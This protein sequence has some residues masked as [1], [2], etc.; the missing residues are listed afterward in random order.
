MS[1]YFKI[2]FI[3]FLI[4]GTITV[5]DFFSK[6]DISKGS[7]TSQKDDNK[8]ESEKY[9]HVYFSDNIVVKAEIANSPDKKELGLSFR[10]NL[11]TDRGML[12]I[13]EVPTVAFFW[14]KD[15]RIPLD[16]IWIMDDKIVDIDK[17]VPIPKT[18]TPL[19]QLP[20]YSPSEKVNYVLEVNAGFTDKNSIE[21]GDVVTINF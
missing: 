13:F 4:L 7:D 21:V 9:A 3:L 1:K 20:K 18:D 12:F 15:M 16:I 6:S 5:Q 14:M 2:L 17:N 8:S 19:T 10:D 11:D